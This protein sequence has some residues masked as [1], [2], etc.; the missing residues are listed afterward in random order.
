VGAITAK[1]VANFEK[2]IISFPSRY[3]F[4]I[5]LAIS[6]GFEDGAPQTIRPVLHRNQLTLKPYF[7]LKHTGGLPPLRLCRREIRHAGLFRGHS[8]ILAE[9]LF[10]FSEL[11]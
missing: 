11:G 2:K 5:S 8:P 9:S 4:T 1:I 3:L 7:G 10:S 6:L